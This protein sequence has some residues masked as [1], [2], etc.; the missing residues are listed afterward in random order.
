MVKDQS[1]LNLKEYISKCSFF[2][3]A[4]TH[5]AIAAYS[6]CVPTLVIGYSVKA[7]GIAYDLFGNEDYVISI[8]NLNNEDDLLNK[9]VDMY[10]KKESIKKYLTGMMED[11]KKQVLK[12]EEWVKNI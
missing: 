2:I 4:R 3:G 8:S 11:Y 9:F 10:K 7:R 12:I 1:A 6:T 5:A